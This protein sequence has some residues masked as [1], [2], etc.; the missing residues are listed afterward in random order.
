MKKEWIYADIVK[1]W[2]QPEKDVMYK[3]PLP[4][5]IKTPEDADAH[6]LSSLEAYLLIARLTN[7]KQ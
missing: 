3:A 5:V 2:I 4:V 1:I 7:G 6:W